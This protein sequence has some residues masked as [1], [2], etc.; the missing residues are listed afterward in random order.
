MGSLDRLYA[1]GQAREMPF[2]KAWADRPALVGR[3]LK[4]TVYLLSSH[5]KGVRVAADAGDLK[6]GN[7]L[8]MPR[9]LA[10]S[11]KADKVLKDVGECGK[12]I[13]TYG[14]VNGDNLTLFDIESADAAAP[15]TPQPPT[16]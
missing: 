3:L 6:G 15:A 11:K 7:K 8:I 5:V 10:V 4:S 12:V 2:T 1:D 16:A 14:V 13:V 9:A